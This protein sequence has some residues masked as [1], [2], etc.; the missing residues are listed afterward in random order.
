MP[1][2]PYN[3]LDKNLCTKYSN[4]F[5]PRENDRLNIGEY[6]NCYNESKGFF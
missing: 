2:F 1:F 6:I 4:N 3:S 5:Y